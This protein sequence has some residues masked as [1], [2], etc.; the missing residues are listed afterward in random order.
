M[1]T[2]ITGKNQVTLPADIVTQRQGG[3]CGP[4]GCGERGS[5]LA[6]TE[7][8]APLDGEVLVEEL[9]GDRALADR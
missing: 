9:D 4:R 7:R 1:I 2:T 8:L 3:R 5:V 6:Q